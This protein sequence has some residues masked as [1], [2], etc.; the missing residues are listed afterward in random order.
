[1][2]RKTAQ[3][4]EAVRLR[5]R[6]FTYSEIA[7]IVSISKSTVS[8][9]LSRETWS[10]SIA[11]EHTHRAAKENSKRISLLNKLRATQL[12][13]RY[14]E[15]EQSAMTEY[16]HYKNNSLF[17]AGIMVYMS[18]GDMSESSQIRIATQRKDAHRLFIQFAQEYLG[19]P[20][21]K[22]HFWLLLY[23]D[24]NPE[25]VSRLWSK[26]IR[27]RVSHFYK[28]QVI[29]QQ[30]NNETLHDGVG[31]TIIGSTVLKRKLMKWIELS[32]KEL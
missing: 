31:N 22:I 3:Y 8:N 14:T 9:W 15:T 5:K 13:K 32:L 17:V 2:I 20:R 27:L 21:E 4:A 6:G 30:T 26:A 10:V 19:V 29:K 16:K 1:M 18:I 11:Q 25:N 23:P 7:N 24:H 28:Y 12:K